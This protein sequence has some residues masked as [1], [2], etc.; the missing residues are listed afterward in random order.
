V[1]GQDSVIGIVKTGEKRLELEGLDIRGQFLDVC[2]GLVQ[3][4]LVA[5]LRSHLIEGGGIL[6]TL[7]ERPKAVHPALGCGNLL[8]GV[9]G[10]IRIIPE[11]V[12]GGLLL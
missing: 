3:R 7:Y 12:G 6:L 11:T 8:Q 5:F 4:R 2:C 1:D 10:G 9:F